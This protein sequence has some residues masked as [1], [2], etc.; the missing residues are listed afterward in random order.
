MGNE[1]GTLPGRLATPVEIATI[2]TLQRMLQT[3]F[4]EGAHLPALRRL[5]ALGGERFTPPRIIRPSHQ[6]YVT[7]RLG[8]TGLPD[9]H[10]VRVGPAWRVFGFQRDDPVTDL[11]GG[12][13]VSHPGLRVTDALLSRPV[14][15]VPLTWAC[16][17]YASTLARARESLRILGSGPGGFGDDEVAREPRCERNDELPVGSCR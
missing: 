5:W 8:S 16:L 14:I 12:G 13:L 2:K 6:Q 10:F 3:P 1:Q 17:M 9:G 7:D 4:D 11:R 15:E